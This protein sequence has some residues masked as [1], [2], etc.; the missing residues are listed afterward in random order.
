MERAV[1][2]KKLGSLLGKSLGYRVDNKAPSADERAEARAALPAANVKRSL[3]EREMNERR[4]AVLAADQEYQR[5]RG[6]YQAAK[7]HADELASLLHSYKITVGVT[8]SMFFHVKA[9]GDSWEEVIQKVSAS[10][11]SA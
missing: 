8:S 4:A 1:A 5:L 7:K 9:Q 6:E 11:V 3:L 2:I 10:R